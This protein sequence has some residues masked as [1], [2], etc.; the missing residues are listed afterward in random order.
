MNLG[1]RPLGRGADRPCVDRDAPSRLRDPLLRQDWLLERKELRIGK[2]GV[3]PPAQW[4]ELA[5]DQVAATNV[6]H[7][8]LQQA[9]DTRVEAHHAEAAPITGEL[10]PQGRNPPPD[11]GLD[12][13]FEKKRNAPADRREQ[14]F[15][16]RDGVLADPKPRELL[17]RGLA[18]L[19]RTR[20]HA[21]AV[22]IVEDDDMVVGG[23]PQVALD[24][25][26][27]FERGG[28]GDEAVLR[29]ARTIVDA[30]VRKS[31]RAGIERVR[32]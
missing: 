28:E 16:R 14:I 7:V 25:G 29:K 24:S 3:K 12:L 23:E 21:P 17:Q 2:A 10:S 31:G 30:P 1:L 22:R 32:L 19:Q 13:H 4:R 26:T 27:H 18:D 5:I 15:E 11:I 20:A 9:R 6:R 8:R